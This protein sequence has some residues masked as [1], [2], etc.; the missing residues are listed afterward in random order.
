MGSDEE[1]E[2]PLDV[3]AVAVLFIFIGS[4]SVGAMIA[5]LVLADALVFDFNFLLIL[6]GVGLLRLS[7]TA[8]AI[9]AFLA[10]LSLVLLIVGVPILLAVGGGFGGTIR[11]FGR[12]IGSTPPLLGYVALAL[13]AIGLLL[14]YR[15][16]HRR[17]VRRLF[18]AGDKE[19]PEIGRGTKA[20][21]ICA[22]VLALFINAAGAW[23]YLSVD[24]QH[25]GFTNSGSVKKEGE[26]VPVVRDVHWGY[27]WG[28]LTYVVFQSATGQPG[29]T[30]RLKPAFWTNASGTA[31]LRKPDGTVVVLLAENQLHEI[32]D[33]EY[34]TTDARVTPEQFEAFLDSSPDRYTIE[35]LLSFVEGR[36][37][38]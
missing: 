6:L 10:G 12:P 25:H 5:S 3:K 9:A 28:K 18:R 19:T 36:G 7:D 17:P 21:I 30:A 1:V 15:T 8:R 16:V 24:P 11:V 14:I 23:A 33:G 38:R 22:V 2:V 31:A 20:A 4:A 27:R 34:R 37:G 35:A 26:A 32:I 13:M 29:S